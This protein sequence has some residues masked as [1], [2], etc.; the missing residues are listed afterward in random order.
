MSNLAGVR[1]GGKGAP[2]NLRIHKGT[3]GLRSTIG[4]KDAALS[5]LAAA[6]P[7]LRPVRAPK[8]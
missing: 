6:K 3:P 8:M 7:R 4:S 2:R 5:L 1:S